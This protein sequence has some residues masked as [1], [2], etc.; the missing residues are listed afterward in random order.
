MTIYTLATWIAKP[1][2]EHEFAQA[3]RAMGEATVAEFPNA[4]GTLIQSRDDPCRFVSFG[5][6]ESE[7]AVT[8]WR[9][10]AA[11]QEGFARIQDSVERAEPGTYLVREEVGASSS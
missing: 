8:R 2:R 11:F 6:W 7:E 1:G 10:S 9:E 4:H 5:H 3:W